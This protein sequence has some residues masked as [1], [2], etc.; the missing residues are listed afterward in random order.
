MME[1]QRGR[2][3][4]KILRLIPKRVLLLVKLK[5]HRATKLPPMASHERSEH[6]SQGHI[7]L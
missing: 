7:G 3:I 2:Q 1:L 5:S 4:G 6:Q